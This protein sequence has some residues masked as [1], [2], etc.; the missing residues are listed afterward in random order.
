M[1]AEEARDYGLIDKVLQRENRMG[2]LD[3]M[4]IGIQSAFF[5][6]IPYGF[7]LKIGSGGIE[8]NAACGR[9]SGHQLAHARRVRL[10]PTRGDRAAI[11][12]VG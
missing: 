12:G 6:A 8:R 11:S 7:L 4:T 2:G 3:P 9:F 5:L 10:F 1:T